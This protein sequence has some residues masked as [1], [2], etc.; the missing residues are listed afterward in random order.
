MIICQQ[1]RGGEGVS[2]TYACVDLPLSNL[3]TEEGRGFEI[4]QHFDEIIL[5]SLDS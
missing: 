1:P 5:F 3:L 2:N 4:R